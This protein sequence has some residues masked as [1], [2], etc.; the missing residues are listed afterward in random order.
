MVI[1]SSGEG[2]LETTTKHLDAAADADVPPRSWADIVSACAEIC[3]QLMPGGRVALRVMNDGTIRRLNRE[4]RGVDAPTD[5]LAF[6]DAGGDG[7]LGDIALSWQAARRQARQHGHSPEAE[8]VALFAHGLLHL[9]GFSHEDQTT[10]RRMDRRAFE[11]CK[12]VGF[13]VKAFG[14]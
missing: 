9:A 4:Y 5:V 6:P 3:Q 1:P 14:H 2:R 13:E 11:L 12:A 8:A 10:R 7:H